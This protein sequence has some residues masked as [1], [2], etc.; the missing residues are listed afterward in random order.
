M[1]ALQGAVNTIAK[2]KPKL[3][4]CI[5]HSDEDMIRIAEW[6]HDNFPEYKL[7]V[8]QHF[9]YSISETVLYGFM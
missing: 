9:K 1:E 4:I 8:R 7:F 5:Y 2:Y 6:I 3:A